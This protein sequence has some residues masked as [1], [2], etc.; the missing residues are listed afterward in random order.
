LN[1]EFFYTFCLIA[2]GRRVDL[3]EHADGLYDMVAPI[4]GSLFLLR[5]KVNLVEFFNWGLNCLVNFIT[6]INVQCIT[7]ALLF[8]RLGCD[9]LRLLLLLFLGSLQFAPLLK[10]N[11]K[12]IEFGINFVEDICCVGWF[13]G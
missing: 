5:N 13:Y 4:E 11:M 8:L 12:D 2:D 1:I 9:F 3:V 7:V 6:S 10:L